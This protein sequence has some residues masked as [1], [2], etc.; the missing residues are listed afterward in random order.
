MLRR[1]CKLFSICASL[2]PAGAA[3]VLAGGTPPAYARAFELAFQPGWRVKVGDADVGFE[4]YDGGRLRITSGRIRACD[5]LVVMGGPAFTVGV[6]IGA[7]PVR[8]A[9]V[10]GRDDHGRVAFARVDFS[11]EPVVRWEMALVPGQDAATLKPDE[12]FGYGV[13]AGTGSFVDVETAALAEAKI[14]ADEDLVQRWIS[15]GEHK[16]PPM[17]FL[18]VDMGPG[19]IIMFHS[20]WGDGLYASWFG[21][22]ARGHVAALLTDFQVIDW[23][24]AKW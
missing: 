6:P 12:I 8:M 4:I 16:K 10:Q 17:F 21:Y 13:D 14:R 11:L 18:D 22:D 24:T 15:E 23:A 9:L 2:L 7:F 19:N 20:G 3:P 5:P 1:L